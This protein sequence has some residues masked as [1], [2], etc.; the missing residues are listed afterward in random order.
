MIPVRPVNPRTL[1]TPAEPGARAKPGA[2]PSPERLREL[3]DAVRAR[4]YRVPPE[5]IAA[6][7]LGARGR[8]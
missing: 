4:S 6:A 8:G 3:A 7:L 1:L 2:A 5:R